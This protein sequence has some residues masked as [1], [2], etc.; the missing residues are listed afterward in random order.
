MSSSCGKMVGAILREG[1]LVTITINEM[2]LLIL[3]KSVTNTQQETSVKKDYIPTPKPSSNI[4]INLCVNYGKPV[5]VWF[6]SR[7]NGKGF[8]QA[9]CPSCHPTNSV[10]ALTE[11]ICILFFV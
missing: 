3:N 7:I 11:T 5:S 1:F 2:F 4:A 9:R 10:K 8:L 6:S